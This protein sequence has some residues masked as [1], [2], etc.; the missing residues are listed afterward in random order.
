[1]LNNHDVRSA[2]SR[3]NIVAAKLDAISSDRLRRVNRHVEGIGLPYILEGLEKFQQE[4]PGSLTIQTMILS[5]WS[6]E[7]RL[8]YI[9][10]MQQIMPDE[11]QLNSPTRPRPLIH[12]L[13]ARGNHTQS[14]PYPTRTLKQVSLSFLQAF[15]VQIEEATRIPVRIAPVAT[16]SIGYEAFTE[17]L[18]SC[19]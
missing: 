8:T 18:T 2:L 6:F 5:P 7:E 19:S 3:A 13:E 14:L 16:N 10:L 11:I 4:Y 1:M 12:Q 15:A 9:D 17:T